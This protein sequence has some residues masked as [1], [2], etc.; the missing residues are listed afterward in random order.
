ME[1]GA[2]CKLRAQHNAGAIDKICC[3]T[4]CVLTYASLGERKQ[5]LRATVLSKAMAMLDLTD[6]VARCSG[7]GVGL[8]LGMSRFKSGLSH[9][10]FWLTL[11]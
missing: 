8:Q 11:G 9:E 10:A 1:V 3:G 6:T 4:F 7:S 2:V 5:T